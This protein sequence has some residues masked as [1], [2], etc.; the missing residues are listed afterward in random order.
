MEDEELIEN[1]LRKTSNGKKVAKTKSRANR[2]RNS[3][4]RGK[5]KPL[6]DLVKKSIQKP[7]NNHSCP[8]EKEYDVVIN[9][10]PHFEHLIYYSN[11]IN[12]KV[13]EIPKISSFLDYLNLCPLNINQ[14]SI[15]LGNNLLS[16]DN[17]ILEDI[18]TKI[19]LFKYKKT[20]SYLEHLNTM[21]FR[22]HAPFKKLRLISWI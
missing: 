21:V 5:F 15:K 4:I 2:H 14:N 12:L 11:E 3:F 10:V 17:Q 7:Q 9:H 1:L 16:L 19:G 8:P 13:A 20:H 22:I 18:Y 6:K